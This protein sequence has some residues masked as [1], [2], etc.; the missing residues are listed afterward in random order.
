MNLMQPGVPEYLGPEIICIICGKYP[1]SVEYNYNIVRLEI[2][3]V[4]FCH[5]QSEIK[6]V[7]MRELKIFNKI[8]AFE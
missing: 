2:S 3:L 8:R 5:G 4:M 7:T 6:K 1:E